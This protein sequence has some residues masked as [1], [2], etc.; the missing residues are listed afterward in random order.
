MSKNLSFNSYVDSQD[1]YKWMNQFLDLELKTANKHEDPESQIELVDET[2]ELI[3]VFFSE[4]SENNFNPNS[5]FLDII[6]NKIND[7]NDDTY[8][9]QRQPEPISWG[10]WRVCRDQ[11]FS[12]SSKEKKIIQAHQTSP[13]RDYPEIPQSI[14][15]KLKKIVQKDAIFY[16][17]SAIISEIDK[18]S[19]VPAL[20]IEMTSEES[21]LRVLDISRASNEWQRRPSP[22]RINSIKEFVEFGENIIANSPMLYIK[23]DKSVKIEGDE[24]VINFQSFLF[25]NIDTES[26]KYSDYKKNELNQESIDLKPI[27]LIDGQH[28]V[29]GLASSKEGLNLRIPIIIFPSEFSLAKAAKVFAEI[30]TLQDSLKPLHKLF[31]QHRFKIPSPVANRNFGLNE[32][33]KESDKTN[34]RANHLSYELIAKLASRTDSVL[35]NKVKILDQNIDPDY[36]IKADIWVN[37]A[38][39]WFTQGPYSREDLWTK[40]REE[41]IYIEVNSYFQAFVETVNHNSWS[42][43]KNRWPNTLRNKS[44]LQSSTH[45]KVLIDL[46]SDVYSNLIPKQNKELF[47]VDDFKKV[48]LP[49]KWVDW[50]SSDLR[51]LF[52]GGGEKGRTSLYIWMY[53]ALQAKVSHNLRAVMSKNIKSEAGKGILAPP[54]KSEI[55]VI[56]EWPE[57]NKPVEILSTRPLN[58]R[59][60]SIW[61]VEDNNGSTYSQILKHNGNEEAFLNYEPFMDDLKSI[62]ITVSWSNAAQMD[63]TSSITLIKNSR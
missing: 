7:L 57:V 26:L 45:F 60:K 33:S 63:G 55:I 46:F 56:G 30:N 5:D 9:H 43:K 40:Q 3:D 41:D 21:G 54:N 36:Y 16:T 49:F 28:R 13:L 38:R 20:P 11:I 19:T 58:A 35:H 29:R 22:E 2:K 23:D 6:W 15:W 1:S 61:I 47:S 34:S 59:R 51:K 44:I 10:Q 39:T 17:A 18:V 62:K 25:K 4:V 24:L 32:S 48:L 12:Y 53:D 8:A 50:T 37:Y 27:W 42:D 31:M 14:R 52:G